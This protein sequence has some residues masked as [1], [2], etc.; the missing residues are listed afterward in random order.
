MINILVTLEVK[1][2]HLLSTFENKAAEIMRSHGGDIVRAFET[3]RNEDGSGQEVH[4]LEFP[5]DASFA[6][7]RSDPRLLEL[8]ED[9]NKAIYSTT[10]ITSSHVKTYG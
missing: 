9:R 1:D 2:F 10:V 6:A 8:T 5:N 7:Y 4:L 3:D